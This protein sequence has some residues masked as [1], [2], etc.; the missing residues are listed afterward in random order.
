MYSRNCQDGELKV[1]VLGGVVV[2]EDGENKWS[3]VLQI[4]VWGSFVLLL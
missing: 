3:E 1:F 4:V 2:L